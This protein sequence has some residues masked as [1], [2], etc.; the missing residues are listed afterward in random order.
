[1]YK[2]IYAKMEED[3]MVDMIEDK[4]EDKVEVPVEDDKMCIICLDDTKETST[5]RLAEKFGCDCKDV[6]HE[7]CLTTWIFKKQIETGSSVTNCIV[8]KTSI[9]TGVE[10][11]V[12][13]EMTEDDEAERRRLLQM[14]Q[15]YQLYKAMINILILILTA[16]L[17]IFVMREV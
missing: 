11:P 15:R 17:I 3:V 6:V 7:D 14:N 8:C 5:Y 16:M 1:M 13:R 12:I 4:V 2:V 9:D 10:L